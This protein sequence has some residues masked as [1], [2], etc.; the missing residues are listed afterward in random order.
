LVVRS[1]NKLFGRI[2]IAVVCV[3]NHDSYHK[4]H[5]QLATKW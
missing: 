5:E 2:Q 1:K 3:K 4:H